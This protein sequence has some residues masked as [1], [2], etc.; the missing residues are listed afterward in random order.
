MVMKAGTMT[1]TIRTSKELHHWLKAQAKK[2]NRSLNQQVE[3]MLL[4]A[5]E[6]GEAEPIL[7]QLR[8]MLNDARRK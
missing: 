6:A 4:Q 2:N 8:K 3:W 1:L 7:E 5:R